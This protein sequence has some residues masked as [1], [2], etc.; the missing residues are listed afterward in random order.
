MVVGRDKVGLSLVSNV[1]HSRSTASWDG[2]CNYGFGTVSL[3]KRSVWSTVDE[4]AYT[5]VSQ[6]SLPKAIVADH[7]ASSPST[8]KLV[9]ERTRRRSNGHRSVSRTQ[10][11]NG[12]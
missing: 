9:A 6:D 11:C 5:I 10:C 1:R 3:A 12:E 8:V 4:Q 2:H 7:A